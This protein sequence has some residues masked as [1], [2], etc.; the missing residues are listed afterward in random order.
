MN[1]PGKSFGL[2]CQLCDGRCPICD[3][4][5]NSEAKVRICDGCALIRKRCILCDIRLDDSKFVLE[6]YYCLECVLQEKHREGCPRITNVGSTKAD[7]VFL[8]KKKAIAG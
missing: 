4:M 8:R 7:N 6:A 5:V 2:L 3:S 1:R